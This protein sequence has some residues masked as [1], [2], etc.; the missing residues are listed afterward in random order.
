MNTKLSLWIAAAVILAGVYVRYFTD[1]FAKKNIQI[2]TLARPMTLRGAEPPAVYP[3]AFALDHKY[4][5][6]RI[7]VTAE[8]ALKTNKLAPPVWFMTT[9]SNS[10]PV[11]AFTYG[12][13]VPGMR[14]YNEKLAAMP[15]KPNEV[16]RVYV[17][18]DGR[19]GETNF[20]A[21]GPKIAP[22]GEQAPPIPASVSTQ[23]APIVVPKK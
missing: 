5:L 10:A 17:E 9:D 13:P 4:E 11:K 7:K 2:I 3:V 8:S 19:F 21:V 14:L 20:V 6:T 16:Y 23:P 12:Q 15:L 22:K 1:W 18:T